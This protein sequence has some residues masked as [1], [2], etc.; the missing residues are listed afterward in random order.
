MPYEVPQSKKSLKQNRFEFKLPGDKK[1]YSVPLLQYIRPAFIRDYS[2]LDANEFMVKFID[3]ELPGVL[4]KLED[5]EQLEALMNAWS[6]ASGITPGE[7]E[8]SPSS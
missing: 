7:S 6:E 4:D 1:L 5:S 8:A 2:E 3:A